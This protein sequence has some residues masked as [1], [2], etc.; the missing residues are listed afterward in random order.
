MALDDHVLVLMLAPTDTFCHVGTVSQLRR[1]RHHHPPLADM[2]YFD[3]DGRRL[4]AVFDDPHLVTD[5]EAITGQSVDAAEL[6]GRI[7][8]TLAAAREEAPRHPELDCDIADIP[9]VQDTLRATLV[10]LGREMNL[11][12]EAPGRD[13]GSMLHNLMHAAFG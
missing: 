2:E 1:H 12:E 10:A 7:A 3:E 9:E 13:P 11:A 6:Q 8:A 5:F 4:R